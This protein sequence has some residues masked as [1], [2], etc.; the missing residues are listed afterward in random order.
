MEEIE[1]STQ[2]PGKKTIGLWYQGIAFRRS[3]GLCVDAVMLICLSFLPLLV[4]ASV[5]RHSF[6]EGM[7]T[8][9]KSAYGGGILMFLYVLTPVP[10]ILLRFIKTLTRVATPGEFVSGFVSVSRRP[11]IVAL[12]DQCAFGFLQYVLLF[13]SVA[14]YIMLVSILVPILL[15]IV[16][17]NVVSFILISPVT[18]LILLSI[19]NV[20]F[21]ELFFGP[22]E[23]SE[24]SSGFDLMCKLQVL[25]LCDMKS[26][27]ISKLTA[28]AGE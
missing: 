23:N 28:E 6:A 2:S 21:L 4:H 3:L 20:L 18:H 7:S 16:G 27:E 1:K 26:S 12:F 8:A 14:S 13:V 10:L 22:S 25:P 9:L 17:N 5:D 15:S 24:M 11:L 19:W